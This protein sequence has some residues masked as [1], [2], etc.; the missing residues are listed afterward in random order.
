MLDVQSGRWREVGVGG[1]LHY[2]QGTQQHV[3]ISSLDMTLPECPF[4]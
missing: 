1:D 2:S 4:C 3:K